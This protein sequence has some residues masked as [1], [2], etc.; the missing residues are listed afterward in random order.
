MHTACSL[1]VG[2]KYINASWGL[3]GD[4]ARRATIL[5]TD[6]VGEEVHDA[7][8]DE[9]APRGAGQ[10]RRDED[11]ARHAQSVRPHGEQEVE[12]REETQREHR[13]RTCRGATSERRALVRSLRSHQDRE[14]KADLAFTNIR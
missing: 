9:A 11:A 8:A 6:H 5:L 14:C 1:T 3:Q 2:I 4:I 12:R 13:V 7:H 10:Q